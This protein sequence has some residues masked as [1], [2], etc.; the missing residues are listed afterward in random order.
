MEYSPPGLFCPR[1]SPG[2]NT[3]DSLQISAF[4]D[5]LGHEKHG[6]GLTNAV[7]SS[8]YPHF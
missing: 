8:P 3:V 2:K 7:C 5:F 4:Q 1:D 6:L